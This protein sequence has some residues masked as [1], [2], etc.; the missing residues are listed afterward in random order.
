VV[1]LENRDR[2]PRCDRLVAEAPW[3]NVWNGERRWLL[4]LKDGAMWVTFGHIVM[5]VI[6]IVLCGTRDWLELESRLPLAV[7]PDVA[8]AL[9]CWLAATADPAGESRFERLTAVVLRG[10][11]AGYVGQAVL[12]DLFA[13]FQIEMD[14]GLSSR[15]WVLYQ[16]FWMAMVAGATLRGWHLGRRMGMPALAAVCAVSGV[17]ALLG[18]ELLLAP[19]V[20]PERILSWWMASGLLREVQEC[21]TCLDVHGRVMLLGTAAAFWGY[22]NMALRRL[23]RGAEVVAEAARVRVGQRK[24]RSLRGTL[25]AGSG[26]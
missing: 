7:L 1:G 17:M 25:V 14:D 22:F 13:T 19:W 5:W 24:R 16:G 15:M 6:T 8:L 21:G 23:E 4:T 20:V 10:A 18:T 9:G 12:N 2:C 3:H 26:M 11:A